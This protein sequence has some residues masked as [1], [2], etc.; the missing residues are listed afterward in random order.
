ML[1]FIMN[2]AMIQRQREE[3]RMTDEQKKE[4][5]EW[6][7]EECKKRGCLPTGEPIEVLYGTGY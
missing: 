7:I 6:S 2:S 5:D 4:K 3:D 1:G